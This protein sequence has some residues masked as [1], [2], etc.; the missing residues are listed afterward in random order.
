MRT[1]VY[2][3]QKAAIFL[4]MTPSSS[5]LAPVNNSSYTRGGITKICLE[6]CLDGRKQT[7]HATFDTG[8]SVT[9]QVQLHWAWEWQPLRLS[10]LSPCHGG[11]MYAVCG[12]HEN[13]DQEGMHAWRDLS[14]LRAVTVN[15]GF[16]IYTTVASFMCSMYV[17]LLCHR[18][19]LFSFYNE[20][21]KL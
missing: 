4:Y 18:K 10:L 19:L 2:K 6:C 11:E 17:N 21:L 7:C 13:P 1:P 14:F 9:H 15:G 20:Q 5:T 16:P 12:H 8:R 3:C